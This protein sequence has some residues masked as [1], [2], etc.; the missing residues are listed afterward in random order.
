MLS[1]ASISYTASAEI[2]PNFFECKVKTVSELSERGRFEQ[3]AW[4]KLV[5]RNTNALIFDQ[6]SG[7]L[8]WKGKDEITE[9]AVVQQGTT[10]NGVNAVRAFKGAGSYVHSFLVIETYIKD[11]PFYLDDDGILY[12]GNCSVG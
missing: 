3:S 5:E 10:T 4:T 12:T 7:Q 1:V 9:F 8:R 11:W 2:R 6:M